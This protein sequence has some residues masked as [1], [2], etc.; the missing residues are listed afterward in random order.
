[1]RFFRFLLVT[2]AALNL[3]LMPAAAQAARQFVDAAGRTVEIPD[4]IE[5]VLAAGPPASVL[6]Y[7]LAPEKMVGWV[8]SPSAAEKEFLAEPFRDLPE[9]GRLTGRG[10]TA[11][12]EMV[13]SM[14]PDII[15]D[16]G[17]ID[18]TYAS[19]ADRVQEQTGIPYVLIDG[20]FPRTPETL[21]EVA[22][23]LGVK[24]RGEELA[25]YA[26]RTM[27]WQKET[28]ADIAG[29]ERPRVYYGR[30]PDGLE[31]GSAG[32]INMEVLDVVGA[33]NV[34]ALAGSG[35]LSNVSIEQ[36]LGWNPDVI[37]TL[38]P[39]FQK[40]V[41]SDPTWANLKAVKEGRVYRAPTLPFGWF[42]SP[43]GVNRLIAV[44]WLTAIL[45]PEKAEFDLRERTREFYRL[46]YQVE[47]TDGQLDRLLADS[48]VR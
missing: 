17:S 9:T 13:L 22:D 5:R 14:K 31:T 6:L 10:N 11:N 21:R 42:D 32:S 3:L 25:S 37:L 19:L 1:M 4:R 47:L 43:P 20:A 46:F 48:A 26:G 40:S 24:A 12:I 33:A 44:T 45:Y 34:A 2:F 36:V 16:V 39:D 23:V 18:P 28:V 41:M 8:R 7:V 30:G 15:I 27:E 35:G 29:D 38:S